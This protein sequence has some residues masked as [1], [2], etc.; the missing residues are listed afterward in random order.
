M[1]DYKKN[2]IEGLVRNG[3]IFGKRKTNKIRYSVYLFLISLY[4]SLK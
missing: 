2:I 1:T 3:E 4:F